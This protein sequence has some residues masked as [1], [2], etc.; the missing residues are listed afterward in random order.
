[1]ISKL[2]C[3]SFSIFF[4]STK[5]VSQDTSSQLQS[6]RQADTLKDLNET[7]FKQIMQLDEFKQEQ[8]QVD[9]IKKIS[10]FPVQLHVDI[11]QSSFLDEDKGQNISLAFINEDYPYN[12]N[13]TIYTIKFDKDKQKI[14]LIRKNKK[15]FE[16]S[17]LVNPKDMVLPN[18]HK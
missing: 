5:G 15:Q 9:S 10:K 11:V 2:L 16:Q 18:K 3:F 1:M 12:H 7:F 14:I 4:L 17:D 13:Q 8:K 6:T